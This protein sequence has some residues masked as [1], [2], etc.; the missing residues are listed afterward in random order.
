M[1]HGF[2]QSG[3]L[4]RA[5]TRALEKLLA[6]HLSPT[7]LEL[8]YPTAPILLQPSDVPTFNSVNQSEHSDRASANEEKKE[9]EEAYGWWVRSDAKRDGASEDAPVYTH[10][11]ETAIP[12]LARVLKEQG[13]FDGVLGFSQGG[14]MAGFLASLL[15]DG[16]REAFERL[17]ASGGMPFPPSL[18]V[19]EAEQQE[20]VHAPLKFAVIYS[21]FA[22]VPLLDRYRAFYD[23]KIQTRVLKFIGS[24]DTVVEESRS[25]LLADAVQNDQVEVVYHPGGHFV[26]ASNKGLA[27]KVAE[28]IKVSLNGADTR[29]TVEER[30]EDMDVPF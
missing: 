22:P 4:F 15:E 18:S 27:G 21:G 13:P 17:E 24:V 20:P 23:P 26:P 25:L 29:D 16:R 14:C 6:K 7:P 19:A 12:F 9:T 5:K 2:T 28:F 10:L 8:V 1:L 11:E 3:P 30:V